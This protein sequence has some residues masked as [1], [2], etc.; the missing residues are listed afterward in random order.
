MPDEPRTTHDPELLKTWTTASLV[1]HIARFA[2]GA[3]KVKV[4]QE[5]AALMGAELNARIPPRVMPTSGT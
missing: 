5:N 4:S 2:T 1:L 3:G